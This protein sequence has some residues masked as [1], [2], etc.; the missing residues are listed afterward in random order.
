M[1]ISKKAKECE[2]GND[3]YAEAVLSKEALEELI[4]EVKPDEMPAAEKPSDKSFKAI[5]TG[6]GD[7]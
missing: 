3:T 2:A 5:G 4:K 1:A 7:K 6:L